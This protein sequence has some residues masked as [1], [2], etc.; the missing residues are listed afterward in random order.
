MSPQSDTIEAPHYTD[1]RSC[2][3]CH[4]EIYESYQGVAMARSFYRPSVGSVIE[5]Y[6][7]NNHFFHP[8]SNRHYRMLRRD[9]RFFQQRYQL[10]QRREVNFF[11]QE[12][13]YIIGSGNH[14]R[15]YLN[16]SSGG[17][18]TQLPVTWYPQEKRWGMS[19][20]YDRARHYDFS[21]KIDYGCLFCH[22]ANLK[23]PEGADRYGRENLFPQE[24]PSGIDCQ[25]CHGPGSQHVAVAGGGK[26]VEAIRQAIVNPA[27]L[28]PERQMDVCQQC[29]LET[30][31]DELPQ[32]VRAFGRAVYSFRP[33]E[34]LS[35]YL[36][37]FDHALG[38]GH[39]DKFE[40]NSSSYRL[41]Q[42]DCFQKSR[43]RLTCTS[44][45]NPHRTPRG[46]EAVQHF[47]E[48]CLKCH[49]QLSAR[50][51]PQGAP[52]DCASCHMP[53]RRTED[54]VHAVMT[55]HRIQRRQ[56]RNLQT[57]RK[58]DH[59][60]YRGEVVRYFPAS[61]ADAGSELYWGI[62]QVKQKSNW[63]GLARFQ[64]TVQR[65]QPAAAEP[66]VELALAQMENGEL[67]AAK[68][69]FGRALGLDSGLVLARYN[70]ARACQLLG[71]L[72]EAA[73]NY[74]TVLQIDPD[75]AEAHNN[76][77]LILQS[78]GQ[79]TAAG[80]HFQKA[81][82]RSPLFVDAH[83]NLG[84]VL[85]EEKQWSEAIARFEEALRIEPSSADAYN[86]LGKAWG[87]QGELEQAIRY[88]HEAVDADPKHWI[89]HLN[90][91]KALQA[92]GK[93]REAETAYRRAKRL[94]PGI[95]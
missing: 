40:I 84:N 65:E 60:P 87:A 2:R 8:A 43:G 19:P 29:H 80:Q 28:S 83:N 13:H 1:S 18:L 95:E 6:E 56:K 37:H 17:V 93:P 78:Q 45:H 57:P 3:P 81:L 92:A 7:K 35:D 88:F 12:V 47:R 71:Q 64:A 48:S 38:A 44:C 11:E 66:W 4:A 26:G 49:N 20:G 22:N 16:V 82:Q 74:R 91:A 58:E 32:A 69:G 9:G 86:N 62:A 70:L 50:A 55:D 36:V 63:H 59:A 27:R 5:D 30:T 76:L 34:A 21:R 79:V 46:Q 68:Q 77:G 85:A 52:S 89:A 31:S 10:K 51:H 90:L 25:R 42:S 53:K 41:R 24:L 73:A 23:L 67:E 39:D 14:A 75:H 54:V 15:S 33:G 72:D 61:T 94:N